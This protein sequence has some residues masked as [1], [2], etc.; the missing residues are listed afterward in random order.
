MEGL[1]GMPEALGSIP[2]TE[3]TVTNK[4][5]HLKLQGGENIPK[6]SF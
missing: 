2:S 5:R 4:I 6:N 1:H 3:T